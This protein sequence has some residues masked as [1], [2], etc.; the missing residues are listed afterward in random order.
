MAFDGL[1]VPGAQSQ[2]QVYSTLLD[3]GHDCATASA[4]GVTRPE[5][6]TPVL[7]S[8]PVL[9]GDLNKDGEVSLGDVSAFVDCLTGPDYAGQLSLQCELGDFESG[10]DVDLQDYA[11]FQNAFGA[12]TT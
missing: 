10:G 7:V 1:L 4:T 6:F 12:D 2:H 11:G 5:P 8:I 9:S 3:T